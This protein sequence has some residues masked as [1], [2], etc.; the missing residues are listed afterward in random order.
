MIGLLGVYL[1]RSNWVDNDDKI[2]L[3][4]MIEFV[5]QPCFILTVLINYLD[6]QDFNSWIPCALLSI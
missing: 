4:K 2:M 3:N 1:Q 5:F 6:I